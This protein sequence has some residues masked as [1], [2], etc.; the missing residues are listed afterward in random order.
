MLCHVALKRLTTQAREASAKKASDFFGICDITS[1]DIAGSFKSLSKLNPELKVEK[2]DLLLNSRFTPENEEKT[3]NAIF[4]RIRVD[5]DN[6]PNSHGQ[7][8]P[9]NNQPKF[10]TIEVKQKYSPNGSEPEL[11]QHDDVG[12][13]ITAPKIGNPSYRISEVEPVEP[14]AKALDLLKSERAPL[15][16]AACYRNTGPLS[17]FFETEQMLR[18]AMDE[19]IFGEEPSKQTGCESNT[20]KSM[21]LSGHKLG[22]DELDNSISEARFEVDS[23]P[24]IVFDGKVE[25]TPLHELEPGSDEFMERAFNTPK[26]PK[27]NEHLDSKYH[28]KPKAE[29]NAMDYLKAVRKQK[30]EPTAKGLKHRLEKPEE[31]YPLNPVVKLDSKGFHNYE[32]QVPN[33]FACS[34]SQIL[35]HI[36]QSIIYSNY[37]ILAINKP[38]GIASHEE[39]RQKEDIDMNSLVKEVARSLKIKEVFLAHRLDKNTTG[40]LLFSTSLQRARN[41][42]KL[43][44]SDQIKKTYLCI[45]TR[46]PNPMAGIIDIPV[47]EYKLAGKIRSCPVSEFGD[48][49]QQL[50][51]KYREARRAITEYNVL[52]TSHQAALVEVKPRTGV[53]HQIRCHL[54]FALGTPILGDHKYSHISRIAP[55]QLGDQLLKMLHL[56][57][58]KVRTLPMHLHAKSVVI[59]NAKA[60]GE[61]LFIEAQLPQHFTQNSKSLKLN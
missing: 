39:D 51:K 19:K 30:V 3:S 12:I 7:F 58:S 11:S 37:D 15:E 21:R 22:N 32:H 42:Q 52:K 9:S 34:R 16:V 44:K 25:K 13:V 59:P 8:E 56:R 5:S 31:N 4:G 17:F 20:E 61:T 60:N 29:Q 1:K 28:V 46:V 14:I 6:Q 24:P 48:E 41:L 18:L 45:T 57:Q 27:F 26:A 47:G 2:Y 40:V 50:A 53:K 49:K 10:D 35:Q 36:K 38:Y 23:K 55:Q 54:G 33:W 43:F